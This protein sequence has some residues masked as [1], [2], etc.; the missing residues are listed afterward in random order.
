MK[1]Y[2]ITAIVLL[3]LAAV[4]EYYY[5]SNRKPFYQLVFLKNI[6][7]YT[8]YSKSFILT[9]YNSNPDSISAIPLSNNDLLACEIDVISIIYKYSISDGK[10][11][12]FSLDGNFIKLNNHIVSII[13]EDNDE[14]Y[15]WLVN[16][17]DDKIDHLNSIYISDKLPEKYLPLIKRIGSLNHD[18]GLVIDSEDIDLSIFTKSIE[19]TWLFIDYM[20][21]SLIKSNIP[22]LLSLELLVCP[23]IDLD[24]VYFIQLLKLPKLKHLMWCVMDK[25]E[26]SVSHVENDQIESLGFICVEDEKTDFIKDFHGLKEMSLLFDPKSNLSFLKEIKDLS[27]LN[28]IGDSI[29]NLDVL[30]DVKSLIWVTLPSSI[31]QSEL[32]QFIAGHPKVEILQFNGNKNLLDLSP[33]KELKHLTSLTITGDTANLESIYKLKNLQHLSLPQK[34]VEDSVTWATLKTKFPNTI[35]VPNTGFCLGSG[36]LLLFIPIMLMMYVTIDFIR[37]RKSGV[38]KHV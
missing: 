19:P 24:S 5:R 11:L 2:T 21:D 38:E 18:I 23:E 14:I 28:L 36:W 22:K 31:K 4:I 17:E 35:I 8:N 27:V 16:A 25:P 10:I 9:E 26:G 30:D 6:N 3:I 37:K 34:M 7:S 13:L 1:K 29:S 32:E 15:H 12:S 20:D 33:L